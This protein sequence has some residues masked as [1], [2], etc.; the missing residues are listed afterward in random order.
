MNDKV[1]QLALSL[2]AEQAQRGISP[3]EVDP[4]L[5][6]EWIANRTYPASILEAAADGDVAAIALIR[7]EAGLLPLV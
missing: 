1:K 2:W 6:E 4:D 3:D 5:I 7:A